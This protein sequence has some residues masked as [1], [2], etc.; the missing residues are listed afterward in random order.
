MTRLLLVKIPFF[1]E[2]ILSSFSCPHC[3][4]QNSEIQSAGEI[5]K[6]GIEFHLKVVNPDDLNRQ[7]VTSDNSF[8]CIPE[9]ELEIPS[10]TQ[11]GSLT[12][13]EGILERVIQG[14]EQDQPTRKT[15]FPEDYEKI[16]SFIAEVQDCRTLKTPFTLVYI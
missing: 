1:K 2:T 12:N 6:Q 13:I 3:H 7:V 16:E 4:L 15:Q 5:Q 14:L 10:K 8:I 9:L 11:R